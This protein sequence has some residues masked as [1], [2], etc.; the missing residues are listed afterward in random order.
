MNFLKSSSWAAITLA[1]MIAAA[2]PAR[3][4]ITF[5]VVGGMS[6][7]FTKIGEE[8]KQGSRGAVEAINEAG[9]VLGEKLAFEVFDD[10]CNAEKAVEIANQIVAKKI[11]FVMGHLCSDASI[12]ASPIY[13]KAGIIEITPSSTNPGLTERGLKY[14]FR[15][16]GR[17]DTQGF[18]LA[19]HILRSYKTKKLGIIYEDSDYGKGISEVTKKFLNQ[20]GMQEAFILQLTKDKPDYQ[21][22]L[23]KIRDNKVNLILLAAFPGIATE[24]IP[25]LRK[26]DKKIKI[27]G[28]DTFTG[29]A[30]TKENRRNYDGAQFSFPPDPADDRRNKAIKKKYRKAGYKPEAFTFYTYGAVQVWAQAVEK[31]GSLKADAVAKALRTRKFNTV[32]GEISFNEKGDISN[33]GFVMYFFNK[34]KRYYFD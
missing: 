14:V 31:A 10:E 19:E 17:D 24:F 32:L 6:G 27:V 2:A 15:T 8:F 25:M 26:E 21:E 11:P 18:V 13:E 3:A 4:D 7:P 28:G 29:I 20:A 5:A 9:G 1:G 16:I 34:G 30:F 22:V 33:P 12:A 23:A